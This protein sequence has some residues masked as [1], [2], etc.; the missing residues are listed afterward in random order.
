MERRN[1]PPTTVTVACNP[2]GK[3]GTFT[4]YLCF[5]LPEEPAFSTYY[6]IE[7]TSK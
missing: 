1:G 6:K 4:A 7:A 2:N 5:I 3:G